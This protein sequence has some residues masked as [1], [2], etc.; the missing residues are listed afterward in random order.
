M[1]EEV[2]LQRRLKEHRIKG[3]LKGKYV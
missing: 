2:K 3:D 1:T